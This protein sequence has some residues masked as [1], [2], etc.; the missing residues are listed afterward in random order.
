MDD[1][2]IYLAQTVVGQSVTLEVVRSGETL[3]IEVVLEERPSE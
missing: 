3:S 1:L 2:V